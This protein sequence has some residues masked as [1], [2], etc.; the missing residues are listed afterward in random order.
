M[1]DFRVIERR[2]I[3]QDIAGQIREL[4]RDGV[5]KSGD[6]LPSERELA[7]RLQVSRSSLREAMRALEL[8]GLV[9]SRP[10][11][12]TF[13]STENLDNL[14]SIIASTFNQTQEGLPDIFEVRQLLEP[15]IASLA[16]ERATSEDT[17]RME[18]SLEKQRQ[19]IAGGE[20]GVEGDTAFH[21]ALAQ[22]TQNSALVKVI[23]T[24]ADI[25]RESRDLTLQSPGRPLRS[26]AS[27]VQIL[28]MVRSRD[29]EGA[30]AAMQH[31]IFEVEPANSIMDGT[32]HL[33]SKAVVS[34]SQKGG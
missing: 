4:I 1:E 11:A 20:T 14:I 7:D 5:L 24:I 3:H 32:K 21:F 19:Q 25:L 22:A 9:V 6:R 15:Q 26:L 30:R 17:Q 12:G 29:V 18:N 13:V 27:H 23:S 8:Q 2:R 28:E 33:D 31:H 10:G 16:A 34:F